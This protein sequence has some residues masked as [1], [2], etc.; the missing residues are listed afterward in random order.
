MSSDYAE[1]LAS[2]RFTA[3]AS[4][5]DIQADDVSGEPSYFL[6]AKRNLTAAEH[7]ASQDD[8]LGLLS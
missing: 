2:K 4:G 6:V 3:P 8:L 7:E 5:I 1:F